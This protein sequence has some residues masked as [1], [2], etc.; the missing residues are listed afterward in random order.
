M[1]WYFL[2][3]KSLLQVDQLTDEWPL[4]CS[5][6]TGGQLEAPSVQPMLALGWGLPPQ[7]GVRRGEEGVCYPPSSASC[8][9]D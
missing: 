2:Y 8:Q 3:A 7:A 6:F 5:W 1:G 4:L 9:W